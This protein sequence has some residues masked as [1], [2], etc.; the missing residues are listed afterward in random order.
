MN[1]LTITVAQPIPEYFLLIAANTSTG[2]FL[3][4]CPSIASRVKSG[5]PTAKRKRKNGMKN[6]PPLR[7]MT[8]YIPA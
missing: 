6:T 7:V 8:I 5:I 3:N 1:Q 2:P 4:N